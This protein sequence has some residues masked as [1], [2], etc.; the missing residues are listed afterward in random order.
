MFSLPANP[1]FCKSQM[2]P[3]HSHMQ[4]LDEYCSKNGIILTKEKELKNNIVKRKL[5]HKFWAEG[6]E[7][8]LTGYNE[9]DFTERFIKFVM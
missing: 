6:I 7:K 8:T 3:A 2:I 5:E 9:V 4:S 1:A